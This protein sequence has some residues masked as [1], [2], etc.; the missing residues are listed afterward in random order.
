MNAEWIGQLQ[1]SFRSRLFSK[2]WMSS[3]KAFAE[4]RTRV[5][6]D[7]ALTGPFH[8]KTSSGLQA[9]DAI[10]KNSSTRAMHRSCAEAEPSRSSVA[11]AAVSWAIRLK[12]VSGTG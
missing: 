5:L 12:E 6:F 3:R 11:D 7:L 9:D 10:P 4:H 8:E 2:S 1:S